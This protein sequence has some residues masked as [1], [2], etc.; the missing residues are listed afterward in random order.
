[1]VIL[2]AGVLDSL[3]ADPHLRDHAFPP[4]HAFL[5]P[6]GGTDPACHVL[7]NE[8]AEIEQFTGR[9]DLPVLLLDLDVGQTWELLLLVAILF[10]LAR[11]IGL[12][13]AGRAARLGS[14]LILALA[15]LTPATCM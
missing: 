9:I 1:M 14:T 6:V 7:E 15:W 8:P 2:L 12:L 3:E 11:P 5:R 13:V 10:F 4:D